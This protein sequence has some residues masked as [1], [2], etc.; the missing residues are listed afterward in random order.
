MGIGIATMGQ[1]AIVEIQFSDYMFPAFDQLVDE[2]AKY[3]YRCG[4]DYT[5]PKVQKASS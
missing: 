5:I 4:E 1:T 3:R 2:A